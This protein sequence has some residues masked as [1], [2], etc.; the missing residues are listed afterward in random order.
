ML[1]LLCLTAAGAWAAEDELLVTI[2]ASSDFTSGSKT[3]DN[4][5]TVTFEDGC[6]FGYVNNGWYNNG[7]S[8]CS[9]TV[10]PAEGYTITRVKFIT[11][12]GNLEDTS[13]PFKALLCVDGMELK[14]QIELNGTAI[15]GGVTKIEVY[16]YAN[17]PAGTPL[18]LTEVTP[19]KQWKIETM[20]AAVDRH[21]D[22]AEPNDDLTMMVINLT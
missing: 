18:D 9:L 2:N 14:V 15:D 3:F 8:P 10:T 12:Y 13:A 19:G 20:P 21:R 22:G 6:N 7:A 4:K 1:A 16:G 11:D 17:A 5:A